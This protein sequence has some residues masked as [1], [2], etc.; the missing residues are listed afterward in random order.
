VVLITEFVEQE[1]YSD[2]AASSVSASTTWAAREISHSIRNRVRAHAATTT[3]VAA[4]PATRPGSRL[5]VGLVKATAQTI[6]T[7]SALQKPRSA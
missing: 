4:G 3:T 2:D 5:S 7:E 6:A 1:A